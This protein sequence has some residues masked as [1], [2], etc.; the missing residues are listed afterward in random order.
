M[1]W[2]PQPLI[3]TDDGTTPVT[4][5]LRPEQAERLERVLAAR[6]DGRDLDPNQVIDAIFESGLQ[7]AEQ[8]AT[9]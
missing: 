9:A 7:V 4:A 1:S 2:I 5:M 3:T 8:S 6:C